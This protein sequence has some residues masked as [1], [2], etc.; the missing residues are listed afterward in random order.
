MPSGARVAVA[1]S[2]GA[3]SVALALWLRESAARAKGAWTVAGLVHVNHGLRGEESDADEAFCRAFAARLALPIDVVHVDVRARARAARQSLEAAA[4]AAR[5]EAFAAAAER[6]GATLIATG[7][8]RDDQAETVLLRLLRGAGVRGL[9]GIRERRGA[10]VRPLLNWSRDDVQ[11]FL[12]ERGESFRHDSSNDDVSIARNRIRHELLPVIDRLAP[13]GRAALARF[14]EQAADLDAFLDS[15]V[16][17]KA[18]GIVRSE[19]EGTIQLRADR[20][21]TLPPAVS[22]QLLLAA[23]ERVAP[24]VRLT[25]RHV[26]D[27]RALA[28]DSHLDLPGLDVDRSGSVV[29]LTAAREASR[30][31]SEDVQP[32]AYEH[33]LPVPG[34]V[35]VPEAG[36]RIVAARAGAGGTALDL[37]NPRS[38]VLQ[39]ASV[40][41]PFVVRNRRP[42]DRLKPLGAP[43][44]RKVQD[45]LV[46][47]K[48]PRADRDRVPIVVDA[49]GR[50]VWVAGVV[51]AD[52]CRVT[53][54]EGGMV[55]LEL[56]PSE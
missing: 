21:A 41:A 15:V 10:I 31:A 29:A 25:L 24:G 54:P 9:S 28:A 26:E 44:R 16:A 12:A 34:D 47:R 45:V 7:H 6:L 2:G 50:I 11:L 51:M 33:T 19:T 42:G 27:I 43:G 30:D 56:R 4:R 35:S 39:A 22:R 5:Y 48:I 55:I 46:D 18:P 23:A 14:A 53:A 1:L 49:A 52:E 3:D 38:V 17:D 37:G 13:G 36:V 20:L 32:C 40:R 8:T